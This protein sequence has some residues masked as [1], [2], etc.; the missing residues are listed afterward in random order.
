MISERMIREALK[1]TSETTYSIF[2]S[3]CLVNLIY[4]FSDAWLK[5]E[6]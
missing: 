1:E 6:V 4:S 5:I 3:T 2:V